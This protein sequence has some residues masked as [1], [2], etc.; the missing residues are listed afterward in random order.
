[1][2]KKEFEPVFLYKDNFRIKQITE[3]YEKG[4]KNLNNFVSIVEKNLSTTFDDDEKRQVKEKGMIFIIDRLRMEFQFP[5]ATDDFNLQAL[6]IDVRP[7]KEYYRKHAASWNPYQYDIVEGEF[8]TSEKVLSHEVEKYYIYTKNDR[9]NEALQI[10]E[11]LKAQI[12]KAETA[13]LVS[14]FNQ[15]DIR[16]VTELLEYSSNSQMKSE[17]QINYHFIRALK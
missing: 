15:S 12:I 2:K 16:N 5:K 4:V 8:K 14:R 7:L 13:G 1:M 17:W 9:Q 6:G 10:A 3:R 11:D